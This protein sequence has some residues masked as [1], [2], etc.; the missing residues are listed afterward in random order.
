MNNHMKKFFVLMGILGIFMFFGITNVFATSTLD[1]VGGVFTLTGDG[2]NNGYVRL[3]IVGDDHTIAD[4]DTI[5]LVEDA[6]TSCVLSGD[7]ITATCAT[8]DIGSIIFNYPGDGGQNIYVIDTTKS[9]NIKT[10]GNVDYVIIE[11]NH[12]LVT[13]DLGAG[14]S[15]CNHAW[16]VG[17][18]DTLAFL[19]GNTGCNYIEI[20]KTTAVLDPILGDIS[21]T[22]YDGNDWLYFYDYNATLPRTYTVGATET[23]FNG[24]TVS[25]PGLGY[26]VF[27]GV[28]I[29][30]GSGDDVLYLEEATQYTE[31]R[32]NIWRS[33]GNDQITIGKDGSTSGISGYVYLSDSDLADIIVDDSVN[34]TGRTIAYDGY[35]FIGFNDDDINTDGAKSLSTTLGSGADVFSLQGTSDAGNADD[36]FILNTGGGNDTVTIG[37]SSNTITSNDFGADITTLNGGEGTNTLNLSNSGS[38]TARTVTWT[39]T[40]I[41]G[42]GTTAPIDYSNFTILSYIQGIGDDS[43]TFNASGKTLTIPSGSGT[44][45]LVV[46]GGT[47][48]ING[49]QTGSSVTIGSG[50]T[51]GGTGSIDS[52]T[53]T[54]GTLAPGLSP[55]TLTVTSLT[56]N[57]ASTFS[58]ELNG[59][60][61]GTEYDKLISTGAVDLGNATLAGTVGFSPQVGDSFTIIEGSSVT[62]IFNGLENGT[63][64]HFDGESMKITY[65]ATSA[66]LTT[67]ASVGGGSISGSRAKPKT[68]ISTP[69]LT[70]TETICP[71]G[72]KYSTT[73]GLPCTTFTTP[74]TPTIPP[75]ACLITLTLRQGDAGN[76]VRCLQTKLNIT[77]DG[78]FGP[79]TKSAVIAFQKLHGL[80]QD[81]IFGPKSRAVIQ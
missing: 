13:S 76:Q 67:T 73:T 28:E 9:V 57:S 31:F 15:S 37:D 12:A 21:F 70:Q 44:D 60:T 17:N 50:G 43:L 80:V 32:F 5:V 30:P 49:T 53:N 4:V 56:L 38:A 40:S 66:V 65:T 23:S 18:S 48:L 64:F 52:V 19:N 51:L 59:T 16:I 33:G 11:D 58:V 22:D 2:G 54:G 74:T 68:T 75:M 29:N 46:N 55:G 72:D 24:I 25:Y 61:A 39:D 10:A 20:G 7:S 3:N 79:I 34:T 8:A 42:T 6:I 63:E 78:I 35:T 69:V 77:S 81:G 45:T 14:G 26:D 1:A 36:T 71:Q 27:D 47:L 41:T 62:G